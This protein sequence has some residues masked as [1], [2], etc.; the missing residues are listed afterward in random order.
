[1]TW[2]I[3]VDDCIGCLEA[4]HKAYALDHAEWLFGEVVSSDE[5]RFV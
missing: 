1:M 5:L 3:L 2:P 4:D